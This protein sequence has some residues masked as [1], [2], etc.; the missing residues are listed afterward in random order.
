LCS[1]RGA[2]GEAARDGGC[3]TLDSMDAGSLAAAI[4]RLLQNPP[5]L[6]ALA[7]AARAR[8]F[9]SWPDYAAELAAW[10]RTLSRRS[11]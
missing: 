3:V 2:L 1:S 9:K 5:A 11:K 8:T 6:A 4:L 10:L 7:A